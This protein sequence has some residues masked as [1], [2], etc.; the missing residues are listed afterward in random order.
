MLVGLWLHS[1]EAYRRLGRFEDARLAVEE[2]E[3]VDAT[4]PDVWCQYGKNHLSQKLY[5]AAHTS[6]QRALLLDP[7][8]TESLI[9]LAQYYIDKNELGQAEACLRSV[10]SGPGWHSSRGW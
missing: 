10:T 5:E 2:A 9:T 1:A 3:Q 7:E 8:H 4:S 6:L